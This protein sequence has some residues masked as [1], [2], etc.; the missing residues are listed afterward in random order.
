MFLKFFCNYMHIYKLFR[1]STLR[2]R[3]RQFPTLQHLNVNSVD[4]FN[5][6]DDI[7]YHAIILFIFFDSYY[8]YTTMMNDVLKSLDMINIIPI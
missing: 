2:I 6:I 4:M 5:S 8:T 7:E 3:A 1:F